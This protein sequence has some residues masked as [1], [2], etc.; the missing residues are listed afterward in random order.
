MAGPGETLV[1]PWPP[2]AIRP[3]Y[4]HRLLYFLQHKLQKTPL[5]RILKFQP[6]GH[7]IRKLKFLELLKIEICC[8]LASHSLYNGFLLQKPGEKIKKK[9]SPLILIFR[10]TV[11]TVVCYKSEDLIKLDKT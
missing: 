2:L 6:F 11:L 3:C 1:S 9:L 4:Y 5:K 10:F 8:F 7:L